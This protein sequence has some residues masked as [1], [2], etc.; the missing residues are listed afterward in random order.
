MKRNRVHV[1]WEAH[2]CFH[3]STQ[4]IQPVQRCIPAIQPATTIMNSTNSITPSP[5][6]SLSPT[7]ALPPEVW[8]NVVGLIYDGPGDFSIASI[9]AESALLRTSKTF[10]EQV[11]PQVWARCDLL[12]LIKVVLPHAERQEA[13]DV[14]HVLPRHL[15]AAADSGNA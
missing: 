14:R 3:A 6:P 2:V 13:S 15:R 7:I 8:T 10:F 4:L 9:L 12:D 5:S 1:A 11:Y